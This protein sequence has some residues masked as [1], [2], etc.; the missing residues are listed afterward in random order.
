[1]LRTAVA[2]LLALQK[3]EAASD[4]VDYAYVTNG[5]DWPLIKADGFQCDQTNQSPIDLRT[6]A[7]SAPYQKGNDREFI[8]NYEDLTK[9]K[10]TNKG[11]VIQA[12]FSKED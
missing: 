6:D 9:A 5:A 7:N 10:V 1:M 2:V 4:K 3:V 12:D 11:M 8:P